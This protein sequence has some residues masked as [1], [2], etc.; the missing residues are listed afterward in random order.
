M[1]PAAFD[2]YTAE[3]VEQALSL[4]QQHQ[5]AKILA[6]G[7]SLIPMMKLRLA[8]PPALIDIGRIPGLTYI[9]EEGGNLRIGA[10]TTH[11]MVEQS[12][13]V[14]QNFPALSD[15]AHV[16]AD[17][18]VRNWGT[19]GGS[20]A[21]ADPASDLPAV[22]LALGATFRAQGSQGTREI[23]ADDFFVDMLTT[24]LGENEILTEIVVPGEWGKVSG[25][26]KLPNPA[27]H[28]AVVGVA[29][30]LKLGADRTIEDARVAITGAVAK[31]TRASATE[32]ALKGKPLNA[33]TIAAAAASAGEGIDALSDIHG[34][35]E[36]RTAMCA[37]FAK[38]A[39]TAAMGRA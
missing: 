33:D 7:H 8:T 30:A 19:V 37:V 28:F 18:Q 32:N 13:V 35:A 9:R 6:G 12:S 16:I 17:V 20:V 14:A 4:L 24:S 23:A 22:L 36:Y 10:L 31:P 25:Y 27:S 29:A 34:S 5:D 39:L 2:Y 26:A 11:T 15:A 1:I 21:H 3:S 38:R